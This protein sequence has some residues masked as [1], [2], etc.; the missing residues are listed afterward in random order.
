MTSLNGHSLLGDT[1]GS[2]GVYQLL[3]VQT[4]LPLPSVEAPGPRNS[5]QAGLCLFT[6]ATMPAVEI[7]ALNDSGKRQ[8]ESIVFLQ[9]VHVVHY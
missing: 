1:Q 3:V 4:K 5:L 2:H 6:K 8:L 9:K 7:W